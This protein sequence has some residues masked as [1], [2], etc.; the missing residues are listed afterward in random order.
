MNFRHTIAILLVCTASFAAQAGPYSIE[1][2]ASFV[3][4]GYQHGYP[5]SALVALG[6]P[7]REVVVVPVVYGA[8]T[9]YEQLLQLVQPGTPPV[10][11]DYV[12]PPERIMA[13]AAVPNG[14]APG[15][16]FVTVGINGNVRRWQGWPPKPGA[17]ITTDAMI[18]E[19]LARVGNVD[20]DP[21][22]ELVTCSLLGGFEFRV[23]DLESGA[24]QAFLNG[25]VPC[26]DLHLVQADADAPLEI[27][28]VSRLIRTVRFHD[29]A[30]GE[31][32]LESPHVV[33]LTIGAGNLD[34]DAATELLVRTTSNE[35]ARVDLGNGWS[36]TVLTSNANVTE[37]DAL[38]LVDVNRDGRNEW[39]VVRYSTGSLRLFSPSS[40]QFGPV[41][42]S[43]YQ[44]NRGAVIA[45]FDVDAALEAFCTTPN[46][47]SSVLSFAAE[48]GQ[49]Q[50][51]WSIRGEYYGPTRPVLADVDGDGDDEL[52]TSLRRAATD[53]QPQLAVLDPDTLAMLQMRDVSL[54]DSWPPFV[55]DQVVARAT[56][57]VAEEIVIG[58][59]RD[60]LGPN[61]VAR[62]N[63]AET[64]PEWGVTSSAPGRPQR[65]DAVDADA[66]GTDEI[67]VLEGNEDGS[68]GCGARLLDIADGAERWTRALPN[69]SGSRGLA[70]AHHPIDA[71][72]GDDV[73]VSCGGQLT[74]LAGSNGAILWDELDDAT[75]LEIV[76]EDG[77]PVLV[78]VS[79]SGNR[80][81]A[82][83]TGEPKTP[84]V[85]SGT[86]VLL[87]RRLHET[88]LR[89]G[90]F[91]RGANLLTGA[92][93]EP[94][95]IG[96][97]GDGDGMLSGTLGA[98]PAGDRIYANTAY[99]IVRLDRVETSPLFS[100][101]FE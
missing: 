66:N 34:T 43:F 18:A 65:L 81:R 6:S 92:S 45:N 15:T 83:S 80:R 9:R 57:P 60:G 78:I 53:R 88:V 33:G 55:N 16:S 5:D 79:P 63:F 10:L 22:L 64:A 39:A 25:D 74:A 12:V 82:P 8:A 49:A 73:L 13:I 46:S 50:Y 77:T 37:N 76:D 52:V 61:Y 26:S 44:C 28:L 71:I 89:D 101:G 36:E 19:S 4:P 32:T 56:P 67:A 97:D 3:L 94:L 14:A 20:A 90:A 47:G 30:T 85:S 72:A 1:R 68:G 69:F 17:P 40:A 98:S 35:L 100:N 38:E 21:A 31:V 86:G 70:I 27:A 95:E 87:D 54:G 84:L 48:F 2:G 93:S 7:A 23:V 41:L 96:T 62:W 59:Y 29:G 75:D 42:L 58:G 11:L 24:T 99:G 51:D 91:V